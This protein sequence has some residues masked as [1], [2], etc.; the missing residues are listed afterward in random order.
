MQSTDG[1]DPWNDAL[2]VKNNVLTTAVKTVARKHADLLRD[3]P[4]SVE[5]NSRKSTIPASPEAGMVP[6]YARGIG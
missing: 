1:G 6:F 2:E 3:Y 4:T 5:K